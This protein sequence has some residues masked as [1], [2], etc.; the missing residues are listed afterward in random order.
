[1]VVKI[2]VDW[3]PIFINKSD[4]FWFSHVIHGTKQIQIIFSPKIDQ[5]APA[6]CSFDTIKLYL[7]KSNKWK[8][9]KSMKWQMINL[10]GYLVSIYFYF[11]FFKYF[12]WKAWWK[13]KSFRVV[14]NHYFP[15]T[16]QN[17]LP[18]FLSWNVP[19]RRTWR[20]H[21]PIC[22]PCSLNGNKLSLSCIN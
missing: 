1:M 7:S 2:R 4:R 8:S 10:I 14:Q 5:E 19:T 16:M 20:L 15:R 13:L 12:F 17:F 6:P 3:G 11:R 18:I 9:E 21:H 22:H